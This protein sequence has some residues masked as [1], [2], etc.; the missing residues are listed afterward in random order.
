MLRN[1]RVYVCVCLFVSFLFCGYFFQLT[2][3]L[4]WTHAWMIWTLFPPV[5]REL[6][7]TLLRTPPPEWD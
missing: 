1:L 6:G 7:H 4:I 3:R 5:R 2:C